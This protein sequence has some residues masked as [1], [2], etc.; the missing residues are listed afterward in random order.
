MTAPAI[1][2]LLQDFLRDHPCGRLAGRTRLF[3]D[4]DL[5]RL[6]AALPQDQAPCRSRSS[7]RIQNAAGAKK[8]PATP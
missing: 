2:R 6:I 1:Y 3:T 7:R 4:E 5:A 8:K